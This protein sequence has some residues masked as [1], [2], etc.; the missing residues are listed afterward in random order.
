MIA[1]AE[2]I[3]VIGAA[4]VVVQAE[5]RQHHDDDAAMAVHDRFRQPGGAAGIDDPER[6]IERQPHRLERM[7]RSARPCEDVGKQ[8]LR[9][10]RRNGLAVQDDMLDRGQRTPQLGHDI[11]PVVPPACIGDGVAGDQQFGFDLLEAVD[12]GGRGHVGRA[13]TPDRTDAG[14]CEKRDDGLGNIGQIGR[15]AVAG[16]DALVLQ[17]QR[18]RG[19]LAPQFRPTRLRQPAVF[20]G[21]DDRGQAGGISRRDMPEHLPGI[22]DLRARKPDRAR[23]P[24]LGEHGRKRR[25]RLQIVIVPDAAPEAVEIAHR[26]SP[27]VLVISKSEAALLGEPVAVEGD[28]GNGGS[29]H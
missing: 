3:R 22:V 21:A 2:R 15:D 8:C 18:E 25:R 4:D 17:V 9:C 29:G 10:G 19:R 23:H 28:L 14:A 11:A 6:M 26:P 7:D 5:Q 1:L 20:T 27:H 16:L 12:H 13:D 24:A